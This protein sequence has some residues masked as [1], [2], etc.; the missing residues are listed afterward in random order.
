MAGSSIGNDGSHDIP[1]GNLTAAQ[2]LR[3]AFNNAEAVACLA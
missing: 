2:I 1:I 3:W